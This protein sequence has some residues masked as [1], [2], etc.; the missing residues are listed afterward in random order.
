[1]K[2]LTFP[3]VF[4]PI[5]DSWLLADVLCGQGLSPTT[6]VLD[7]CSGSGVI[8]IAA[9]R[10]GAGPVTAV[11][12]ARPALAAIALNAR[13]NGVRVRTLRGDLFAPVAGE[14]FDI[15]ASNPP[16]VPSDSD[17]LPRRG[18]TR[19]WEAGLDGRALLDRICAQAPAHLRPGGTLLL[20]HSSLI[21]LDATT[22]LLRA[23]G[24][25]VDVAARRRGP[26][27]PLLSTRSAALE[28]QGLLEPGQ[29]EEDLLVLCARRTG[30]TELRR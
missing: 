13:L 19:A 5:S 10:A 6:A 29:R 7:L 24:L 9:A 23:G 22:E 21:G 18:V 30:D 16:Y 8:A 26:L 28:A 11:D 4:H 15:I 20:V 27:G 1:M 3:G 2:I 17:A 14:R 25:V 12:L